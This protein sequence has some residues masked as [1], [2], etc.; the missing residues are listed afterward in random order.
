MAHQRE[1]S[2]G[3]IDCDGV[4]CPV[5][6]G[7]RVQVQ[8]RQDRSREAAERLSTPHGNLASTY[9][10]WVHTGAGTDVVAYREVTA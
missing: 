3:W 4:R 5:A 10:G 9:F 2:A 7:A 6:P 8:F 1:V